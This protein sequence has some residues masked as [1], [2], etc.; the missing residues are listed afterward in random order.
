MG[1]VCTPPIG[2]L[3]VA[4]TLCMGCL[5][6]VAA[7]GVV[8]MGGTC[9]GELVEALMGMVVDGG[10]GDTE[11]EEDE[12]ALRVVEDPTGRFTSDSPV[13]WMPWQLKAQVHTLKVK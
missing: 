8:V 6:V 2:S 9:G 7:K 3:A 13:Q 5:T 10:T 12:D 4:A 11:E 1:T